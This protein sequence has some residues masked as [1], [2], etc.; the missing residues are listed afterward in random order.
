MEYKF[1]YTSTHKDLI[2]SYNAVRNAQSGLS[3]WSRGLVFMLGVMWLLGF[4][5]LAP[6]ADNLWQPLIWLVLGCTIVWKVA[7][8]PYLEVKYIKESNE[9]EQK[10]NLVFSDN[11]IEAISEDGESFIRKWDEVD[12]FQGFNNGVFVG[13]SDGVMNWLPAR[14]FESKRQKEKF[15]T[16]VVVKLKELDELLNK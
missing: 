2:D 11:Q 14:V 12:A 4:I 10:V 1:N 16:N 9:P 6:R 3:T 15:V 7:I 13:F 5:F 8:K